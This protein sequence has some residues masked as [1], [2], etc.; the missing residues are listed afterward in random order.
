MSRVSI[1]PAFLN[2]ATS[3]PQFAERVLAIGK[4]LD[5][6]IEVVLVDDHSTDVRP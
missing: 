4:Q 5:H 1:I 6:Q 3:L 2:E